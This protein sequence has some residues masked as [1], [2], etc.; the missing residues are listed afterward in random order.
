MSTPAVRTTS[1]HALQKII[2]ASTTEM[3]GSARCHPQP[4]TITAARM[5]ATEPAASDSTWARAERVFSLCRPEERIQAATRFAAR[6][7]PATISIQRPL[8]SGGVLP[9]IDG[10]HH[11]PDRRQAQE[12]RVHERGQHLRPPRAVGPLVRARTR[13]HALGDEGEG[14]RGRVRHHVPRVREQGQ[15][16]RGDATH[17]GRDHRDEREYEGEEDATL[18]RLAQAVRVR[19]IRARRRNRPRAQGG[20]PGES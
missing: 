5:A 9:S 7:P 16:V 1:F 8:T 20:P 18:R 3:R 6:P 2:T 17:D 13:G 19:L 11:H 12:Q 15:A 4:S 14:E 10:L